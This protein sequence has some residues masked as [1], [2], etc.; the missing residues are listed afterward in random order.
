MT[1]SESPWLIP[2]DEN[3]QFGSGPK[4]AM[5]FRASVVAQEKNAGAHHS[6][7]EWREKTRPDLALFSSC[8]FS[9]ALFLVAE[10]MQ[11]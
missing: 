11:T 2:R 3:S 4:A 5:G 6:D 9:S 7:T 10:F 8:F 1:Y